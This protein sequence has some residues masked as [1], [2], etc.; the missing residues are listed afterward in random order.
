M[1][2]SVGNAPVSWGIMEVEGWSGQRL[3]GEVMD[4]IA[5]AG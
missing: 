5:R 4:E 3:W 2:I 1:A